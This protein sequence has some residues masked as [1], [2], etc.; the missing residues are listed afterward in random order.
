MIVN[1]EYKAGKFKIPIHL[2]FGHEAIAVAMNH[3]M[4]GDDKLILSHRNIAY[5]LARHGRLKPILDE[6]FLK[7]SG[8]AEGKLG[9]MN[10]INSQKGIIYSSSILGNNFS[11]ATGVAMAQKILPQNGITIVLGGDGSIEEG[12]F[13]ESLLMLKSLNLG[14]FVIVENNEWSMSTRIDQ[15]RCPIDLEKLTSSYNIK[16][17][18]LEGNNSIEYIEQLKKLRKLAL[19]G[20]PVCIEVMVTTMGDW[21]M[22]TPENPN[23]KFV[24]YHAGPAPTVELK[25]W[26]LL[27]K[28]SE[29]D[30]IF[31]LNKHANSSVLEEMSREIRDEIKKD[32]ST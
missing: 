27:I 16:Y 24:N 3:F 20:M 29:E 19:D 6:Y 14:A 12:T 30:P 22:K 28:T 21:I 7:P 4:E 11:V 25:D 17:V 23:G 13:H 9:S 32:I 8:L 31:V 5:N 2:A 18:R 10:V 26:P 15:R 1:E